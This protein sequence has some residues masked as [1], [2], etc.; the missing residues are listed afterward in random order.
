MSR[1]Y[2]EDLGIKFEDTPQGYCPNDLR[3]NFWKEQREKY[4][5]DSR[6]TWSLDYS[7]RLWLYERLCMF[8]EINT[9]DTSYHKFQYKNMT[10]T[11]Q[12]CIDKMI[13]GLKLD[14]TL[15]RYDQKRNEG[16]TKD[17]IQD[18]IPIFALCNQSL[19]W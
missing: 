5:F 10:L 11:L 15:G 14:L 3:E 18:I 12:D 4:G 9:I 17:K 19:W 7:F 6:E 13:E 2:I 16:E 8:N 1:K